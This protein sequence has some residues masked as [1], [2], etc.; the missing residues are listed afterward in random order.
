M[1]SSIGPYFLVLLAER[2]GFLILEPLI[3]DGNT[4]VPIL[5]LWLLIMHLL[6]LLR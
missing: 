5:N 1:E 2:V 3:G 4:R 6:A